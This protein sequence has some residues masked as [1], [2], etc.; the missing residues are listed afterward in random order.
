[1]AWL[2]WQSD[3][4]ASLFPTCI[5]PIDN[6]SLSDCSTD[7]P[8]QF[9]VK[10]EVNFYIFQKID[11]KEFTSFIH[12]AKSGLQFLQDRCFPGLLREQ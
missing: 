10:I 5:R 1:M 2:I 12:Y 11:S 9:A 8:L 6:N 4:V 3:R 7:T